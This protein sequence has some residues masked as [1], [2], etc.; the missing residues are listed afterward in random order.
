MGRKGSRGSE[1]I[2]YPDPCVRFGLLAAARQVRE[3]EPPRPLARIL[4]DRQARASPRRACVAERTFGIR[5]HAPG[6]R[7]PGTPARS[8]LR[9]LDGL[10]VAALAEQCCR[11]GGCV[12]AALNR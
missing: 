9:S 12:V 1:R 11:V 5:P 3:L 7:R 8:A 2:Q 10:T 4:R 6:L